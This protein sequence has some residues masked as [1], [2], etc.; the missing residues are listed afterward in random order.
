MK[1]EAAFRVYHPAYP[2]F[3]RDTHLRKNLLEVEIPVGIAIL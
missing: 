1:S 3:T 2:P